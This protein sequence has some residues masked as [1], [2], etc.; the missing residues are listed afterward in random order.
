M[1]I[2]SII[3]QKGGCGKTTTAIN[4]SACLAELGCEVLL[5]DLDPQGHSGLGL[6]VFPDQTQKG[7]YA[8]LAREAPL[9][10]MIQAVRPNLD[11]APASITLAAIEQK[12]AG[13]DQ[14]E[15]QLLLAISGLKRYYDYILI[16]CPPNLGLL[17]INALMACDE[18]LIPLEA[19]IFSFH[20]MGRLLETVRLVKTHGKKTLKSRVLVT[21]YDG[22]TNHSKAVRN[23]ITETFGDLL[24]RTV[25]RQT[26]RLREAA[27]EGLAITEH[28][29]SSKGYEDYAG[30]AR[31][32]MAT[33][34]IAVLPNIPEQEY[35]DT[36]EQAIKKTV[37]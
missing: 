3:N 26:V 21:L 16:D 19:G 11:L 33:E 5:L 18:V 10:E 2:I 29:R 24:Y 8:V 28:D 6:G 7:M 17:T 31:E 23:Q 30:L 32:V 22:R 34:D 20:G 14:R 4:L 15:R 36:I 25:I 35:L 9:Q 27:R 1:R 37:G 13:A 12:L